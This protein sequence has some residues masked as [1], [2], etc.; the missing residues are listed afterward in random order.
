MNIL[1]F[2]SSLVMPNGDPRDGFFDP[3]LTLMIDSYNLDLSQLRQDGLDQITISMQSV[4]F[5]ED[6]ITV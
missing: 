6:R 2:A 3:T 5:T 4:R 1:T